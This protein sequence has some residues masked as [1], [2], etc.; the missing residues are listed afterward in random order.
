MKRIS[1]LIILLTLFL[2]S[3]AWAVEYYADLTD[4]GSSNL[5]TYAEPYNSVTTINAKAFAESDDL[6]FKAGTTWTMTANNLLYFDNLYGTAIDR[7]IIGAY[8][9]D[10]D[11]DITGTA[12]PIFDGNF[13]YPTGG[14]ANYNPNIGILN[15]GRSVTE[16]KYVTFQDLRV[17][18]S[19]G[20]GININASYTY[21]ISQIKLIR[22]E[23]YRTYA[24]GCLLGRANYVEVD[25]CKFDRG[26]Y[27]AAVTGMPST[28]SLSLAGYTNET[29]VL[30]RPTHDIWVHHST[31]SNG[32]RETLGLYNGVWNTIIEYNVIYNGG[33]GIYVACV[34]EN[35]IRYNLIYETP[36][37]E[38][39]VFGMDGIS[40]FMEWLE[41]G[42]FVQELYNNKVYGNLIAGCRRGLV[43][44]GF[45]GATGD[46]TGN[47]FYN[48]TIVDCD[49]NIAFV[50]WPRNS[51]S[52]NE[53]KNNISYTITGSSN[54]IYPTAGSPTGVTWA[55]NC[56][57]DAVTGNANDITNTTEADP[58]L[59]KT[60]GWQAL[61][62]GAVD[63]T[64]FALL[65]GSNCI[66]T[67]LDLGG[68][69]DDP[70]YETLDLDDSDFTAFTFERLNQND[71]GAG[72]E[73]GGDI[74]QSGEETPPA[75]NDCKDAIA[76]YILDANV[77]DSTANNN[78]LTAEAA[79]TYSAGGIVLNGTTQYG[80]ID[81]LSSDIATMSLFAN[82]KFDS[83]FAHGYSDTICGEFDFTDERV[84]VLM[85]G[86]DL[87]AGD[88]DDVIR[89]HIG[90][91]GGTNSANIESTYA[92]TSGT[93][94]SVL[95]TYDSVN[96]D[97]HLYIH[98]LSGTILNG[99]DGETNAALLG[100]ETQN[101]EATDFTLGCFMLDDGVVESSLFDGVIY[102]IAL[103]NDEKTEANGQEF[104]M[105][106]YAD[107][108]A[109]EVQGMSTA[110]SNLT[111]AGAMTWAIGWDREPY[112]E[113]GAWTIEA[114]FDYPVAA[115]TMS[116]VGKWNDQTGW[117]QVG[118]TDVW[119]KTTYI[120]P[121]S[122]KAD[123][124]VLT[125]DPG[126]T[127]GT[128]A[129]KWDW[130]ANVLYVNVGSD[131][132]DD[133]ITPSPWETYVS[134]D[135]LAGWRQDSFG[136]AQISAAITLPSGV[137]IT[138]AQDEDAVI[139]G[140]LTGLGT[141]PAT[142]VANP[143]TSA[144]PLTFGTGGNLDKISDLVG[145]VN[146]DVYRYLVPIT[147]NVNITADSVLIT[148]IG[149]TQVNT[150]TLTFTG[151]NNHVRCV[152]FS[153]A[154][155]Y[156]GTGNT[157]HPICQRGPSKMGMN[158]N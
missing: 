146:N 94:Y 24:I 153:G 116:Y 103:Y 47:L 55:Y 14:Q 99:D 109:I 53:F 31:I 89:F 65:A 23:T 82:F 147:D 70:Y 51:P 44:G 41:S 156:T 93:Q 8:D 10:G 113:G 131:P 81:S 139:A 72:W 48:N 71:F 132:V 73:I 96:D 108:S 102:E 34:Y 49:Y 130:A 38:Y 141:Y 7:A 62:A 140:A 149:R 40:V 60:T 29:S 74:Y 25:D 63:G 138:D 59:V 52:G 27:N 112:T 106:T 144:D 151:D 133:V 37:N 155:T 50:N 35:I 114:T 77:E 111:A 157:Y 119:Y 15:M 118:A 33:C 129:D 84:W 22:C 125:E 127:T 134:I 11:F 150:G 78:D 92:L 122:V 124:N 115:Q 56:F 13:T 21:E 68:T 90:H 91:S 135:T 126:A 101:I 128:A 145:Q 117:T 105:S 42:V 18:D 32:G 16:S 110:C 75:N 143:S 152:N 36:A 85:V 19:R 80:H 2:C 9:G 58:G 45:V 88:G 104:A 158:P 148:G 30:P 137:T 95:A 154:I 97:V 136:D 69:P 121:T 66:D 142:T 6:Y 61:T 100:A 54:H 12:K 76:H 39:A 79:P 86:D 5:G 83:A 57:D 123:T 120:E 17:I 67:G 26:G 43:L 64:D 28:A 1:L 87:A 3:N 4:S 46:I 20:R 107:S 98:D